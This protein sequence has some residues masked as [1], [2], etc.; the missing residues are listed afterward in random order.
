MSKIRINELARQLEVKSREVIDKL[1]ELGIA[2]KVTHSSSIDEDKADQLR[3]Y[4]KG[5]SYAPRPATS[6]R[7]GSGAALQEHV[8]EGG[9]D[10]QSEPAP[11]AVRQPEARA[12]ATPAAAAE[13]KPES[14][15][16]PI[17]LLQMQQ[18]RRPRLPAVPEK[19]DDE[20]KPR[21][22]P[23]RPPM[24]GKGPIH[25][26]VG[27]S[28]PASAAPPRTTPGGS[29]AELRTATGCIFS[30]A[31]VSRSVFT[32]AFTCAARPPDSRSATPH[33]HCDAETGTGAF[34]TSSAAASERPSKPSSRDGSRCSAPGAPQGVRPGAPIAPPPRPAGFQ[35]GAPG[36]PR[37]AG[38]PRPT[39]VPGQQGDRGP[40][41]QQGTLQQGGPRPFAGQPA[42]RP[43]VPPRPDL[44]AKLGQQ[45]RP[46]MP[47]QAP[48]PRPGV[49]LRPQTPRPGQPLY[50]G[51]PR[52]GAAP[53]AGRSTGRPAM[54]GARPGGPRPMHPTS[55]TGGLIG[56]GAP[57]PPPDQA[58]RRPQYNQQNRGRGGG[59]DR[60]REPEERNLRLQTRRE[61]AAP[62]P[63]D[64]EITISEGITVKELSEK[65]DVKANLVIKKLVD[66][67]IFATINQTLDAKLAEELAR[68]FGASTNH[69]QL[70]R[71]S[72]AGHR[73]S[74]GVDGSRDAAA[75][76]HH[77]GPR[78]SR[79]DVAARCDPS[80]PTWPTRKP[81]A[82][83]STSALITSRRTAR[84]SSS[85]IRRVTK[86]SRACAPAAPRSPISWCWWWRPT[87][88]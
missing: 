74:R 46:P 49:P 75:G 71:R 37:P 65:L 11:P 6:H 9:S 18:N 84:R 19:T 61:F 16:R 21:A 83:R 30:L 3:R 58:A 29:G 54:P 14:A 2:E 5:E 50:Q 52:P 64:R 79:Q 41:T 22:L 51:P 87:T 10:D 45:T 31:F 57:P 70:R 63:I 68:D 12:T 36:Q 59:R 53:M 66:R 15:V 62:P 35:G 85:S 17:R 20:H 34:G 60:Q 48:P 1:H 28:R 55:R 76:G 56:P 78:R 80:R 69:R 26:P 27:A 44:V 33:S 7:N 73:D 81:A 43:V 8:A 88:A 72:D 4:Y 47:G 32:I 13:P 67:R 39:F 40:G 23:L 25:P 82:S 38:P 77:H 86:R 42:V 24:I